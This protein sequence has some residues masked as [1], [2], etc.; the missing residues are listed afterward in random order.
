LAISKQLVELMGGQIRLS[1]GLGEGSSF[2]L[3][4]PLALDS[5]PSAA[6]L[7]VAA[8]D[9]MRVLVVDDYQICRFVTT[10]LC[11]HWGMR[12][13]E[14]SS[15]EEALRMVAAAAAEGDPYRLICLDHLMPGMDGADTVRALR[16]TGGGAELAIVLI[17]SDYT[18]KEN[19][20]M[21]EAGGDACLLKP[22]REAVLLDT[23]QRVLGNRVA[24]MTPP[25]WTRYPASQVLAVQPAPA[26]RFD[27]R[28]V[29]LVEDNAV[30][31]KVGSA[32][33]AKV[34]CRVDVAANGREALEMSGQL[35]YEMIFMDC[36]MPEMDGYEATRAIRRRESGGQRT[37]IVAMTAAALASDRAQCLQ[38]GMDGFLSKPVSAEHLY[39]TLAQ[40][41]G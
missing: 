34:G 13:E 12:A 31:Q 28:R 32:L 7:P 19:I 22:I 41:M 10:H 4:V 17:T 39:Q 33:L 35:R 2:S 21:G 40:Y 14:A 18:R 6:R 26:S 30:N 38:A 37:P 23:V 5:A 20:R 11:A 27:G 24:G 15:G 29:L 9:G 8:L 36:Q 3:E 1:S 16:K 25:M